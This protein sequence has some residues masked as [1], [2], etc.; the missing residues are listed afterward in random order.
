MTLTGTGGYTGGVFSAPAGLSINPATGA[1]TPSTSTPSTYTVTYT[2]AASG[3]CAAVTAAT[4][5]TI[6]PIVTPTINCGVSTTTSVQFTWT[7]VTGATGYNVSYQINANPIVNVGAIGNVL[8][9]TVNSLTPGDTV[10]ITLT[11]TAGAT[12]CF[13]FSTATCTATNCN[14]PT[15]SI[16]YATPFCSSV[17]TAQ[18][19]T[20]TGTGGYTGGVYSAPAGLTINSATGAITPSTST[21]NTYTVTY[22][23]AASGGCAAVTATTSITI[24]ALPIAAISYAT[25]FCSSVA[26]A[27]SVTL[28][29]SGEIGRAHV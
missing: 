5:V 27:Q 12:S 17:A 3:G 16:S 19:V 20:L 6:N 10:T 8:N 13:D 1:I 22:T 28:T 11:P 29:G 15:A 18:S 25:P 26:T 2:I 14:P 4:S 9:Y 24:T 21:P 23:I 7:A